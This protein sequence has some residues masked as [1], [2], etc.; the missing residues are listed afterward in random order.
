MTTFTKGPWQAI[1][2]NPSEDHFVDVNRLKK[3]AQLSPKR[4][5]YKSK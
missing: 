4:A 3:S 1:A 5:V 2:T